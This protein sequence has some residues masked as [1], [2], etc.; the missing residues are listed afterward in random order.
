MAILF[1]SDADAVTAWAA[2]L[3]REL[4]GEDIRVNTPAEDDGDVEFAVV[5]KPN[6]GRLARIPGLKAI[7][8]LG[9]GVDHVFA[10]PELPA[11]VPVIRL[12][13]PL[14]IAQMTEYV[15]MNVLWHHR[16]M[17][18][19]AAQQAKGE[20]RE[21]DLP[22]TN[23]RRIGIMGLGAMGNA[24]AA[25][26]AQLGFPLAGWTRTERDWPLGAGFHGSD[27]LASFLGI[28]DILVCLL[29]LTPET[30]GILNA[31]AF[32]ALPKGAVVINAARGGHLVEADLLEALA[33]GRL[34]AA[35]LD[36]FDEEPLPAG[37]P[38][39]THPKIT[40]LPHIAAQTHA[41]TAAKAVTDN[42]RRFRNGEKL[43]HVVE[44]ERGY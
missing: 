43:W 6:P 37:H 9:A 1:L 28:S 30:K 2:A 25:A 17:D 42:I 14:M 26:L 44:R 4:A 35:T 34:S 33:T 41:A 19:Y 18:N 22:R 8:S 39:W 5:W 3:A 38:F 11:G 27:G 21:L 29:P 7:F 36:V 12:V 24:A 40:V 15:V 16:A 23:A 20:W 31:R 10:D 32:A 13:D